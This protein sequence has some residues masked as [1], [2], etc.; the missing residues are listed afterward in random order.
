MLGVAKR[1]KWLEVHGF[2]VCLV[3]FGDMMLHKEHRFAMILGLSSLPVSVTFY[4][5]SQ[6][7]MSSVKKTTIE[8]SLIFSIV[9]VFN[10]Y[11]P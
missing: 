11:I 4:K 1:Q 9:F 5:I 6:E 7:H 2:S 8:T 3:L 10:V